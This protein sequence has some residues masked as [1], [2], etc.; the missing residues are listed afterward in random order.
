[1]LFVL[2]QR[3]LRK[4][5]GIWTGLLSWFRRRH[6]HSVHDESDDDKQERYS[7]EDENVLEEEDEVEDD[8]DDD[9]DDVARDDMSGYLDVTIEDLT[10]GRPKES[11]LDPITE[12]LSLAS[13]GR[14]RSPIT[15]LK[16]PSAMHFYR[17]RVTS[18]RTLNSAAAAIMP[19]SSPVSPNFSMVRVV[20]QQL[21]DSK[22]VRTRTQ[23][24]FQGSL[25]SIDSLVES[26]WDPEDDASHVTP[27]AT[28]L[29]RS[30]EFFYEHVRFLRVQTQPRQ[31]EVVWSTPP[32]KEAPKSPQKK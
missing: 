3:K 27:V 4:R 31:V 1:M 15:E 21:Q 26:Y 20:K 25:E 18:P 12:E 11:P 16:S 13:A 10:K 14:Q 19:R 7:D 32:H 30:S 6:F 23:D 28:N 24:S 22:F 17:S 2:S 5:R 9:D 8:D 29:A